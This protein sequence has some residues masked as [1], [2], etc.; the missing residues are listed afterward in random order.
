MLQLSFTNGSWGTKL[1]FHNRTVCPHIHSP[2]SYRD[3]I[4]VTSFRAQGASHTG[5]VCLSEEGEVL[6]ETG[7]GQEF[8]AGA[9]LIADGMA[10]IMHGKTGQLHLFELS[11]SGP[12]LLAQAK[13][14]EAKGANV[15][16]PLALSEG[17][18]LVRDQ[19]QLKCLDVR[20]TDARH[21]A[22]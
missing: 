11:D 19:H 12:K 6:W 9:F 5:L 4:Y 20:A 21:A 18:L 8:D 1:L 10:F 14:L 13:V 7:P 15:W 22:H 16:A 2:V 3:R 17:K